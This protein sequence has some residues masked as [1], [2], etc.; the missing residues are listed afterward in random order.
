[1]TKLAPEWVRTSDPVIRSPARYRWTTAPATQQQCS[2]PSTQQQCSIPSAQKQCSTPSTQQQCSTP[3]TQ[4][5][6]SMP[7]TQQQCSTPSTQQQC[8]TPSTQQQC[9]MPSMKAVTPG[10]PSTQ[11]QHHTPSTQ[12]G[13]IYSTPSRP[14]SVEQYT[15][16]RVDIPWQTQLCQQLSLPLLHLLPVCPKIATLE[17]PS[18]IRNIIGDGNCY[19]RCVSFCLTG[20]EEFHG[21][22]RAMITSHM[23][24]FRRSIA[25]YCLPPK[26]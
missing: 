23:E 26:C 21:E 7:S 1:M 4:Q 5:Q 22:V 19:F 6:C 25:R 16:L 13:L 17:K 10:I 24:T 20:S 9:S 3:S 12:R 2:I 14:P 8:S 11:K 15:F 18:A